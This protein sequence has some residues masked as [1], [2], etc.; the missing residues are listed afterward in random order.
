[1]DYRS[2][3]VGRVFAVRFDE[4]DDFLTELTDL[5]TKENIRSGWFH[6][7]G[8]LREAG[9]VTGPQKPVMPPDPVWAE[10]DSVRETLGTGTIFWDN[11]EPKI[12]LHA[13]LGHHGDTLTACVRK[14]TKVYL[15]L[16]V[17]IIETEGINATRP[18]YEKG[19]FNRLTFD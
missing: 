15:V 9:V 11:N 18:W 14:N 3:K 8:G 12:H 2:G 17:F 16:E 7:I 5:I 13:A 10:L 1:M 19:G 6:V 4:G